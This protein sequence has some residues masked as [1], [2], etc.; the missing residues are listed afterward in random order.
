MMQATEADATLLQDAT[1]QTNEML[2]K[3]IERLA[4]TRVLFGTY[5]SLPRLIGGNGQARVIARDEMVAALLKSIARVE[6]K[7]R[8]YES[9]KEKLEKLAKL[10]QVRCPR[11]TSPPS[12]H[13][14]E[15]CREAVAARDAFKMD[16][17]EKNEE[18]KLELMDVDINRALHI[19]SFAKN[20]HWPFFLSI[21]RHSS[22][23]FRVAGSC[24][25]I[26]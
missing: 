9:S 20:V 22:L 12:S 15:S 13:E 3:H 16:F 21:E 17:L 24:W 8:K 5:S 1:I 2:T 7:Q 26:S 4:I 10:D 18:L 14:L 19:E 11:P 6:R 23:F 25:R